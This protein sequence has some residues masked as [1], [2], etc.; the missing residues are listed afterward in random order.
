M[1]LTENGIAMLSRVLN[2]KEAIQVNISIMR[3]FIQKRN[4]LNIENVEKKTPA[5]NP[6][7]KKITLTEN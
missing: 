2:S 6:Q 3:I 1:L 4:F 5:V 7:R